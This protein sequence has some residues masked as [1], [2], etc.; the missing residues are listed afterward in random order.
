MK[1]IQLA[2]KK[3]M[4]NPI[5][6]SK[7]QRTFKLPRSGLAESSNINKNIKINQ[8]IVLYLLNSFQRSCAQRCYKHPDKALSKALAHIDWELAISQI[9]DIGVWL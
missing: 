1:I 8:S 3:A 4:N 9:K 5:I 6:I 7:D 2:T